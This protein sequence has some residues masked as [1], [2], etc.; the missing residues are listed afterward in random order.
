MEAAPQRDAIADPASSDL[1]LFKESP[2]DFQNLISF[3]L[4]DPNPVD[5]WL[6]VIC[7]L[8]LMQNFLAVLKML[9]LFVC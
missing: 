9:H 5:L 7:G 4:P 3:K 2:P 8:E 6:S 1:S